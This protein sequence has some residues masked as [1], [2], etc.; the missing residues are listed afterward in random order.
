VLE[1]VKKLRW[2]P[3]II[4]C[5]GWMSALAPLYIKKAYEDDPFFKKSKIVYSIF[6]D[7]FKKPLRESF[8]QKVLID[9]VETSHLNGFEQVP[10][11][12]LSLSKLAI[13]FS[14]AVIQASPEVNQHVVDYANAQNKKF[15]KYQS[16]DDYADAYVRFYDSLML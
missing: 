5:Q 14:D 7:D 3:D 11:D 2:T 8:K 15:L 6:N 9:G 10:A 12:F 13:D 4:H 1:T 16:P